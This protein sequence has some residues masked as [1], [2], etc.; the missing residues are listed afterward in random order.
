MTK[1]ELIQALE[2]FQDDIE[3]GLEGTVKETLGNFTVEYLVQTRFLRGRLVLKT[4]KRNTDAPVSLERLVNRPD[5]DA[6][7]GAT[8]GEHFTVAGAL[9]RLEPKAQKGEK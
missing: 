6:H 5:P 1:Q 2:P 4:T 3:I 9:D 7:L 8:E